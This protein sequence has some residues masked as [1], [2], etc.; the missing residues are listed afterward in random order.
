[1]H[2]LIH[3][4]CDVH[5]CVHIYIYIYT[6]MHICVCMC[7]CIYIYICMHLC[8]YIYIYIHTCVV[9]DMSLSLYT[10]IHI[11]VCVY[12]YIHMGDVLSPPAFWPPCN[13]QNFMAKNRW[14]S[15][16]QLFPNN[17]KR[18][19][20]IWTTRRQTATTQIQDIQPSTRPRINI[21]KGLAGIFCFLCCF[22]CFP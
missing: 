13:I 10:Y 4:L 15:F 2:I 17:L 11:Y 22:F 5:V 21:S 8:M 9:V 14:A 20:E 3:V 6:H 19:G 12:I 16:F 18:L 1:M 7:V